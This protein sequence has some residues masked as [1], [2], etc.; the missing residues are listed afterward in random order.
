MEFRSDDVPIPDLEDLKT[1]VV[2]TSLYNATITEK[3]VYTISVHNKL[4][5]ANGN[6][7][8]LPQNLA[9]GVDADTL[10]SKQRNIGLINLA[11]GNKVKVEIT[12]ALT[13]AIPKIDSAPADVKG[14]I[15]GLVA[16]FVVVANMIASL[17]NIFAAV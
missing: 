5:K 13:M 11:I 2:L 16:E 10:I 17:P 4:K 12:S 7:L 1:M 14:I 15:D 9:E 3:P 6:S 8:E